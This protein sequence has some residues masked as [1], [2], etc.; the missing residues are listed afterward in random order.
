VGFLRYWTLSN[1]P[2]FVLAFPMLTIMMVSSFW[3]MQARNSS[4]MASGVLRLTMEPRERPE[5]HL[6]KSLAAPQLVLAILALTSYHVQI[7]TRISSG[8]CVWYFWLAHTVMVST[9]ESLKPKA[10]KSNSWKLDV[11]NKTTIYIVVYAVVQGG[12][13]SSFLPP[14]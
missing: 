8:Y 4:D 14:A 1:I 2:L 13:F 10:D 12:L 7:I 5:G 9:D 6:L 3:A 11:S